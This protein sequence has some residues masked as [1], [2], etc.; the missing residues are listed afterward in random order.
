[1]KT[2]ILTTAL[3]ALFAASCAHYSGIAK[4]DGQIYLTGGTT[5]VFITIP[6]IKRCDMEG[7]TL[8]CEELKEYEAPPAP[9]RG[10]AAPAG[11]GAG[12]AAAPAAA[13]PASASAAPADPKKK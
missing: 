4:A 8:K 7:T 5:I 1:M 9:R 3:L 12:S 6:F 13:P 10:E 2:R 11:S